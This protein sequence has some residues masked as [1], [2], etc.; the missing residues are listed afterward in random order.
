MTPVQPSSPNGRRRIAWWVGALAV[1]AAA[2][3]GLAR[4]RG[5]GALPVRVFPAV[6]GPIEEI[7]TAV[8]A[9]T[10]K[11]AREAVISPEAG[12]TGVRFTEVLA[13]AGR[14]VRKGDL[15]ARAAD[16]EL[17]RESEAVQEDAR[18]AEAVLR[19]SEARLEEVRQ[20]SAAEL[21][22]AENASRQAE[23]DRRRAAELRRDGFLSQAELEAADTR[24]ADA[25]EAVR[26]S[27]SGAAA[28]L[29]AEREVEAQKARLRAL[30]KRI[31]LLDERRRKLSVRAPF[32]GIITKKSVEAGETKIAGSPL[33]VL[34]DPSDTYIEAE[35]DETESA[36]V[37]VGMKCRL[38]P[39]AYQG[40][41]FE[42]RVTEVMPVVEASKEVS[43]ANVVRVVP[44]SPPVLFRLGMSADVEV[45]VGRK[46]DVL[47]V[48]SSA[49]MEREGKKFVY[50][51]AGGKIAR[52]DVATGIGNWDRTEILSGLSAG[53]PV[54]VSLDQ[55]DLAPGVRAVVR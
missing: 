45:L 28:V 39:D 12:I 36:R 48:P 6:R 15:L 41:S 20:R 52:R 44:V 9:G 8:S 53:D 42:G 23:S 35:I 14:A 7:V 40:R 11:S 33:F 32:D 27:G 54:V 25:R 21:A 49:V 46:D 19:Q 3:L 50:V 18:T 16:P 47:Q 22:R 5:G 2:L 29:A 26:L 10:V 24:L 37:R 38:L 4:L 17:E 31:Q 34:A 30:R 1:L 51:V 13:D 55:K 43:R